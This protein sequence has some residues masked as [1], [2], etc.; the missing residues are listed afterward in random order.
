MVDINRERHG[1]LL[2]VAGGSVP[3]IGNIGWLRDE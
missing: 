2:D 3:P 1:V